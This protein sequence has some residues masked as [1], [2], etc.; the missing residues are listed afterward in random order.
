MVFK[1]CFSCQSISPSKIKGEFQHITR[2]S[3][4]VCVMQELEAP[5][6]LTQLQGKTKCGT[7]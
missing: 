4:V 6:P 7:D 2:A 5:V 3:G 1:P